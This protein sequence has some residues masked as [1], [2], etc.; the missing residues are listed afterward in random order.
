MLIR[1]PTIPLFGATRSAGSFVSFAGGALRAPSIVTGSVLSR[2]TRVQLANPKCIF[3]PVD[4]IVGTLILE[5]DLVSVRTDLRRKFGAILGNYALRSLFQERV[6]GHR[7]LDGVSLDGPLEAILQ[8]ILVFGG[9]RYYR[10]RH[11]GRHAPHPIPRIITHT[12][13]PTIL[14]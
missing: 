10:K 8:R 14:C 7:P 4:T 6:A 13:A 12:G 5:G 3:V 11:L 2:A 1:R 9:L